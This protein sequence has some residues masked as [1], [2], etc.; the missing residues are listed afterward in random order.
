MI[1]IMYAG[2][3]KMFDGLIISAVSTVKHTADIINV[4][5]MTMDL[6]DTDERF[7]PINESQ[8]EFIEKIYRAKNPESR[9]YLIDAGDFYKKELADSPNSKTGYTPYTFLRLFADRISE[10]PDKILYLDADIVVNGDIAQLYYTDI[11][12]YEYA[13]ALDHYGKV[14]MGHNYINAGVMLLNI[15]EIRKTKLFE[16]AVELCSKKKIFL[17]DQTAIYKLTTRNYILP[18]KYNEQKHYDKADTVIQHFTKTILWLPYFHTRNIKP[19]DVERVREVLTTRYDD[20]L[21]EY[22]EKKKEYEENFI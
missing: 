1:S 4:Y 11:Y 8:R 21:N 17:P 9:V 16:K 12:G 20:V 13:A 6:T 18:G 19:W 15:E 5:I 10:I 2:N 14:F 7:K 3:D 22:L